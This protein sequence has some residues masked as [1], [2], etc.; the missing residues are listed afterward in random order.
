VRGHLDRGRSDWFEGLEITFT[1]G[2]TLL[3]GRIQD[4]TALYSLLD[5]MRDL[6]LELISV[7]QLPGHE[8]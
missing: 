4:Q 5:K 6:G 3:T 1:N 7:E 8:T 2:D